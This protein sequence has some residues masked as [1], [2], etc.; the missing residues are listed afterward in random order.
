MVGRREGTCF[1]SCHPLCE[2]DFGGASLKGMLLRLCKA[3]LDFLLFWFL[4]CDK[5]VWSEALFCTVHQS[6][7]L[8]AGLPLFPTFAVVLSTAA[9]CEWQAISLGHTQPGQAESR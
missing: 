5:Q 9:C 3:V 1:F 4:I 6:R 2:H 7:G 8:T